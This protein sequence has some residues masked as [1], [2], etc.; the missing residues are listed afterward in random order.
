MLKNELT[1]L[2]AYLKKYLKNNY[3]KLSNLSTNTFIFF[4]KKKNDNLKLYVNYKNLNKIIV[5]NRYSLSLIKKNLNKLERAKIYTQFDLTAI[6][7]RIRI[8]KDD[9]WKI[10]FRTRYSLYEYRILLFELVNASTIFQL[11]INRALSERLNMSV[12]VYL[13]DILIYFEN[14]IKHDDDV[15]WVL[16]Q[17]KKY[18]LYINRSKNRFKIKKIHF[19]DYVIFS[20]KIII[21]KKKFDAIRE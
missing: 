4:I 18:K 1:M 14:E 6:Y 19:L 17:L 21:Q 8:K 15:I 9:K 7:Y 20:K 11:Y 16:Q 13:N 12:I 3:I 2:R 5:K 10:A